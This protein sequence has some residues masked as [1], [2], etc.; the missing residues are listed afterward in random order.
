MTALGATCAD[1]RGRVLQSY[2][3]V[4]A[5]VTSSPNDDHARI[6]FLPPD[7]GGLPISIEI[8]RYGEVTLEAG[9]SPQ[10]VLHPPA[11]ELVDATVAEV[12]EYAQRGLEFVRK[13]PLLRAMSPSEYR[14]PEED[15]PADSGKHQTSRVLKRWSAWP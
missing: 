2:P 6:D 5:T 15:Q 10:W 7:A 1:I 12:L 9:D 11:G 3:D 4:M 13:I 8:D 14:L